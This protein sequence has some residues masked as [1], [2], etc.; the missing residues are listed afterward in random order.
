MLQLIDSYWLEIVAVCS[1]ASVMAVLPGADF[2]MVSRNSMHSGRLAGLYTTLGVCLSICVHASYTIAGLALVIASSPW[3]FTL[4]KY[5]GAVYLVYI[6][7]LLLTANELLQ[8]SKQSLI[9]KPIKGLWLGFLSNILNPKAPIFFISI[10]TQVINP[11]TP[12]LM[13]LTYAVII[14]VAHFVWFSFVALLLSRPRWLGFFQQHKPL[15]DRSAGLLLM[16]F[17]VKLTLV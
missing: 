16:L 11:D 2:V 15:I 10:F 13:Q 3:L 14:V 4:I 1:V 8:G 17:A 7:Y 6:A 5:L 9:N 12:L